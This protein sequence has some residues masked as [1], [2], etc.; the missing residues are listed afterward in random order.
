M[1]DDQNTPD[2]RLAFTFTLLGFVAA[3]GSFFALWQLPLYTTTSTLQGTTSQTLA[4]VNGEWVLWLAALP[5][6]IAVVAWIGLYA[7]CSRGSRV[8]KPVAGVAVGLL[9]TVALLGMMSIG[10]FLLPAAALLCGAV[11]MTPRQACR[12]DAG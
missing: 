8:G 1:R 5:C 2:G 10:M 6:V 4:E 11:A 3:V 12:A 7:A 9:G